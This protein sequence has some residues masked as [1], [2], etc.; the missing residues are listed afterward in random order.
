MKHILFALAAPLALAACAT[1]DSSANGE[2]GRITQEQGYRECLRDRQMQA[3][4]W[5]EIER[6]CR[7]ETGYTGTLGEDEK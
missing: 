2:E 6:Q 5:E 7:E 3:V 4:A 1:N